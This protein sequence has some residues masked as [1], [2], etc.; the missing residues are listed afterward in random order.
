MTELFMKFDADGSGEFEFEE[1]RDFYIKYL[2]NEDS[3]ERLRNYANFRF[4]DIEFE[5]L[6]A[7]KREQLVDK[8]HHREIT[9]VKYKGTFS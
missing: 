7:T 2:D 6:V 3:L 1:F 4:R 5:S 8:L 9:K